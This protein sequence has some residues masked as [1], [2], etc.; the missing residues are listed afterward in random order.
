MELDPRKF[1]RFIGPRGTLLVTTGGQD[2][3]VR[4]SPVSFSMPVS[5]DPPMIAI[6]VSTKTPLYEAIKET[7][8]FAVNVPT[9]EIIDRVVA[10]AKG[11][12]DDVNQIRKAALTEMPSLKLMSP[13]VGECVAWFECLCEFNRE[14]GDHALI[15][16]T[17][18]YA[19]VKD[20]VVGKDGS[21]DLEKAKIPL[22][23]GGSKFALADKGVS[24]KDEARPAGK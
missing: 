6:S 7:R 18:A 14:M 15:V 21:I 12:A 20:D 11:T 9:V 5:I 10:T 3:T 2:G 19:S 8:Q 23:I 24:I 1:Y 13:L 22:H 4:A 17:I 16:G